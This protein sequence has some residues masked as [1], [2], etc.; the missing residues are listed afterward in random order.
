MKII[1]SADNETGKTSI[2]FSNDSLSSYRFV[3]ILTDEHEYTIIVDD[4]IA[5]VEALKSLK[6][7]EE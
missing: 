4:L 1:I 7:I 5:V 6:N 3:D 2:A